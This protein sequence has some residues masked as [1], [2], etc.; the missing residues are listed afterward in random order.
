MSERERERDR[1]RERERERVINVIYVLKLLN[2]QPITAQYTAEN[3][4]ECSAYS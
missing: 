4:I 1:E 2:M 3:L